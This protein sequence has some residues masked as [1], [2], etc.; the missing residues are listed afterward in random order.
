MTST[1]LAGQPGNNEPSFEAPQLGNGPAA[2]AANAAAPGQVETP[3]KSFDLKWIL[4]ALLGLALVFALFFN[5]NGNTSASSSASAVAV[6]P[7]ATP[8]AVAPPAADA[9]SNGGKLIKGKVCTLVSNG[10]ARLISAQVDLQRAQAAFDKH[11]GDKKLV[12]ALIEKL[13]KAARDVPV[14]AVIAAVPKSKL[15]PGA[16]CEDWAEQEAFDQIV[17]AP[18]PS[19]KM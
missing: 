6:A 5:K 12:A 8:V 3:A 2:P 9:N 13:E 17:G 14:D 1:P 16:S 11:P 7:P 19:K 18:M 4:I 15:P 10:K